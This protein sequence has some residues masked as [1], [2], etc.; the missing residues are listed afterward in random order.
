MLLINGFQPDMFTTPAQCACPE[1]IAEA[2]IWWSNFGLAVI[3]AEMKSG[4]VVVSV[5]PEL[6]R[7]D[8]FF[9][10]CEKWMSQYANRHM[11]GTL[12]EEHFCILSAQDN[13]SLAGL[14]QL[15]VD[16]KICPKLITCEGNIEYHWFKITENVDCNQLGFMLVDGIKAYNHQSFIELPVSTDNFSNALFVK[17]QDVNH[18][19][20][21]DLV[22]QCFID[23]LET[24]NSMKMS[25][26]K[27]VH[28]NKDSHS[29]KG[30]SGGTIGLQVGEKND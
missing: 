27:V 21:L 3:P 10:D 28:Q 30:Q 13:D 15:E 8:F 4:S 22:T 19:S 17:V 5:H 9:N 24:Y 20:E 18:I 16:F 29:L 14:Y 11:I 2:Y 12:I 6:L 23:A 1:N 26:Q 25:K 7:G